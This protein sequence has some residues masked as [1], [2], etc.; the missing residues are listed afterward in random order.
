MQLKIPKI[1]VGHLNGGEDIV[2]LLRVFGGILDV[3][4]L[5]EGHL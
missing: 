1:C 2:N 4:G 3:E 5:E